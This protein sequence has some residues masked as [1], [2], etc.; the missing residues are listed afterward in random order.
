MEFSSGNSNKSAF[1]NK[2]EMTDDLGKKMERKMNVARIQL[3]SGI[4]ECKS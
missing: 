3:C 2:C 1:L 4:M